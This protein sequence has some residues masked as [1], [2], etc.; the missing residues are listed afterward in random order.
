M[1]N[2]ADTKRQAVGCR[3]PSY[4]SDGGDG[5][6]VMC[7]SLPTAPAVSI[8][9]V[10]RIPLSCVCYWAYLHT[11]TPRRQ[12]SRWHCST[13][14]QPPVKIGESWYTGWPK[15]LHISTCLMLNWYSFVKYQPNFIIV[16][17]EK[18]ILNIACQLISTVL[19]DWH[20]LVV[21]QHNS[22]ANF[23]LR[24]H[25]KQTILFLQCSVWRHNMCCGQC[26]HFCWE[27]IQVQVCQ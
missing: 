22:W 25:R 10:Q 4:R 2:V 21:C 26:M 17:W 20:Y 24:Q 16:G 12:M 7:L 11:Q 15:K 6:K 23:I 27:S 8:T 19:C 5:C 18:D 13:A 1:I 9:R 3:S 14:R